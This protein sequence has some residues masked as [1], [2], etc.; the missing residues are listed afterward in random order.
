M[1]ILIDLDGTLNQH[2]PSPNSQRMKDGLEE[3]IIS[4]YPGFY[5]CYRLYKQKKV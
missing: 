1:I 4:S 2:S 3:T 5:G